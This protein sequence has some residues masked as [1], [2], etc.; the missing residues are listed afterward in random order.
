MTEGG[1]LHG[2]SPFVQPSRIHAILMKL[3]ALLSKNGIAC[4]ETVLTEM[5]FTP[6][7]RAAIEEIA[8]RHTREKRVLPPVPNTWTEVTTNNACRE[9]AGLPQVDEF[10]LLRNLSNSSRNASG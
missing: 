9:A 5:K 3:Y 7:N 6:E 1:R 2:L 4:T 10:A 8:K